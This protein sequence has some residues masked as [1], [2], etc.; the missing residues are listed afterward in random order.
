[1]ENG[2]S[3]MA[4]SSKFA[5]QL[6]HITSRYYLALTTVQA[7]LG[8]HSTTHRHLHP[9]FALLRSELGLAITPYGE[10]CPACN[11]S[12]W[13]FMLVLSGVRRLSKIS[14]PATPCG[15][16]GVPMSSPN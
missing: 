10:L 7:L 15:K 16:K 13:A 14:L 3:N 9:G 2:V 1:M 8:L 5:R 11:D 4:F 6:L 12:L